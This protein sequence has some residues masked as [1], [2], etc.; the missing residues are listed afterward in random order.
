M[1]SFEKLYESDEG[2]IKQMR[3]IQNYLNAAMEK[4]D[5]PD[6]EDWE[7]AEILK[8]LRQI[9]VLN[10][11]V[12]VSKMKEKADNFEELYGED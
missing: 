2:Y 9:D 3:T 12:N 1:N 7:V 6:L 11:A 10:T 4:L 8:G 5:D